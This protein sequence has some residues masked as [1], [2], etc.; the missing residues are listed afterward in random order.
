MGRLGVSF[1]FSFATRI[2]RRLGFTAIDLE[3]RHPID[4]GK[5]AH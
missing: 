5:A 2:D 3:L 1:G 4:V